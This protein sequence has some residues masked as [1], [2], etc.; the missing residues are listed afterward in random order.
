VD[1]PCVPQLLDGTRNHADRHKGIHALIYY[2]N[3]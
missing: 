3:T 2:Y 1:L